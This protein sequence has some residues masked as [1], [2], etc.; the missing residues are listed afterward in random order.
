[1]GKLARI[2]AAKNAPAVTEWIAAVKTDFSY[3]TKE[4]VEGKEVLTKVVQF[5]YVP[6]GLANGH[7]V[8]FR[9]AEE[10]T[11]WLKE[12]VTSIDKKETL[13][14]LCSFDVHLLEVKYAPEVIKK[15]DQDWAA[16]HVR[17]DVVVKLQDFRSSVIA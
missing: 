8:P 5:F 17:G 3:E 6:L 15:Y 11:A 7:V 12:L 16:A 9:S 10:G 2:N 1:M 13:D 14:Q 4:E